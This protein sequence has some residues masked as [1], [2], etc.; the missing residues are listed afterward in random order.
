MKNS[1]D[2]NSL[3]SASKGPITKPKPIDGKIVKH[4]IPYN[5]NFFNQEQAVKSF[6]QDVLECIKVLNPERS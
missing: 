3:A 6:Y 4:H 1:I 2:L 5:E